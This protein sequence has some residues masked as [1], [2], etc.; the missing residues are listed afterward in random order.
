[1]KKWMN[2]LVASSLLL[3]VLPPLT[4]SAKETG[5]VE[6]TAPTGSYDAT[7]K[8]TLPEGKT[9]NITSMRFQM[10]VERISGTMEK[11]DFK[12][13]T[14]IPSVVQDA[15]VTQAEGENSYL[16]D[17]ILSGKENQEFMDDEG[18]AVIGTITVNPGADADCYAEIGMAVTEDAVEDEFSDFPI[19]YYVESVGV[20]RMH[21]HVTC[22]P[23]YVGKEEKVEE[24]PTPGVT[25]IPGGD[26]G[27]QDDTKPE[28]EKT[29]DPSVTPEATPS[30]APSPSIDPNPTPS[31]YPEPPV[32]TPTPGSATPTAT[33]TPRPTAKP[34]ATPTPAPTA[35]ATPTPTAEPMPSETPEPTPSETPGETPEPTPTDIPVWPEPTITAA[36]TATPELT[37]TPE[38][39]TTPEPTATVTP[40]A[41]ETPEPTTTVTPEPT[42]APTITP[43]PVTS[44]DGISAEPVLGTKKVSLSW[45]SV[46]DVDGYVIYVK[47]EATGE[48]KRIKTIQGADKT[49]FTKAMTGF[50]GVHTFKI[51][52]FT[53]VEGA[54]SEYRDLGDEITV[55]LYDYN[56]SEKPSVTA[57]STNSSKVVHIG[58]SK[59]D[60]ADG[61][62]IY[63]FNS[64]TKKYELLNRIA[65][66]NVTSYDVSSGLE[67]G[68]TYAFRVRAFALKEDGKTPVNGKISA[69]IKAT[70]APAKAKKPTTVSSAKAQVQI[71]WPKVDKAKGYRV[72]RST[73]KNGKYT[74][75]GTITN[76]KTL[77]F[78]DT[79]NLKSGKTYYYKVRAYSENPDGTKVYG[80]LSAAKAVKVK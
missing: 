3:T 18:S 39:T 30:A 42:T 11:P 67:N 55:M 17:I 61:Y 22:Q 34:T 25:V 69:T 38:A 48:F 23:V 78:T 32:V 15:A 41:T 56:K 50:G 16:I 75:A 36:P 19:V 21:T 64:S 1:M 29:P 70:T 76:A 2:Y 60:G 58:W 44:E 45:E 47:N 31:E 43:G 9:G 71:S 80:A 77:K 59:V 35:T 8:M 37:A 54:K 33:A 57:S 72:Y 74:A 13:S 10:Y 28:D 6:I 63:K 51:R 62:M 73:S 40:E 4:V 53:K 79:K 68:V 46:P 66:E 65:G 27:E 26:T 14:G 7:V 5:V 24:Q 12:F 52:T 20:Q 49:S